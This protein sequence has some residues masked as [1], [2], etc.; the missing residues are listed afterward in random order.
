MPTGNATCGSSR[1]KY[2]DKGS[3]CIFSIIQD[4]LGAVPE[5]QCI[6]QEDETPHESSKK[7]HHDPFS[8]PP[9]LGKHKVF[10]IPVKRKTFGSISSASV[11]AQVGIFN[12]GKPMTIKASKHRTALGKE[13]NNFC[14]VT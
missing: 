8:N 11:A 5:S 13:N 9:T 4:E 7:S 3:C 1:A 6:T 14:V 2:L 10:F 12:S